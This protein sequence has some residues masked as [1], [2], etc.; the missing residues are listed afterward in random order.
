MKVLNQS[1]WHALPKPLLFGLYG[2]LG[3]LLGATVFGEAVWW[4]LQPPAPKVAVIP[5]LRLAASP[6]LELYQ[7]GA[8]R[9]SVKIAREGWAEPVTL[10]VVDPPPGVRIDAITIPATSGEAEVEVRAAADA[11]EGPKEITLKAEGAAPAGSPSAETTIRLTVRK[12]LPPPPALRL[13][14]S[15][16]VVLDQSSKNH[17]GVVIARDNFSGP[18][19]LDLGGLPAGVTATGVTVPADATRTEVE[20]Q[21]AADAAVGMAN[22]TVTAIGPRGPAEA[23]APPVADSR[24]RVTVNAAK[25]MPGVDVMFVLDVT[26]S[27]QFAIDGVRDGIIEFARELGERKLDARVGLVAFRDRLMSGRGFP[28][29]LRRAMP[30]GRGSSRSKSRTKRADPAP[31]PAPMFGG[32][33]GEEPFLIEVAGEVF[34]RNY[35][36][37]GREVGRKL[38]ANGG[39]DTPESS[40][41]GI[42]LAAAQKF[43][44]DATRVMILITDAPPKVP[45]KD[46]QTVEEAADILRKNQINQLHLVILEQF[47]ETYAPLQVAAPGTVFDLQVAAR[48]GGSFASLLP[49]VSREIAR[50]TVASQPA[51]PEAGSSSRPAP[52]V[53]PPVEAAKALPSIAPPA[54]LRGVQ[55]QET[56]AAESSG[57]LLVAIGA[58]TGMIA[59]MIALALCA[60]QHRYLKEGT[61]PSGAAVRGWLGGLVAGLVG[62]AA[63]QFLFLAAPGALANDAVSRVLGWTLLGSLAGLVLAF[64][65]PNLRFDRGLLGGAVGGAAG[66]LGY[67]GVTTAVRG[68]PGA[69]P[70]G[71]ILGAA[72]LGLALGLMLAIAERMARKAW[73][74][75]CYGGSE[76]RTVNL[77]LQPVSIGSDARSATIYARGVAP[78]AYRYWFKEGKVTRQDAT[79]DQVTEL[80]PGEPESVGAVTVTVRTA[81]TATASTSGPSVPTRPTPV[82]A[83]PVPG[84]VAAAPP[85]RPTSAAP[86]PVPPPAWRPPPAAPPPAPAPVPAS[87][88]VTQRASPA[89]ATVPVQPAPPVTVR[90]SSPTPAVASANSA[91]AGPPPAPKDPNKC[92]SCGKFVPG[93][94]GQ[95]Y[96]IQCD[97][98][99]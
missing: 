76:I 68:L 91:P 56:F 32:D 98:Y 13:S 51:A 77:G 33:D 74:E 94:P 4:L 2:A 16:E 38:R 39:G 95:R 11:S 99:L 12:T 49:D 64:F 1:F 5:P 8:N 66:A 82:A 83:P 35:A 24:L 65:V 7:G 73:L 61:L 92:P 63:G 45:D 25:R 90:P 72:L 87:P 47:R 54:V 6:A 60:G 81:S 48:G 70:S 78:V 19:V 55:S 97:I 42:A 22:V 69:D 88:P 37:F 85:S 28:A 9:F 3:G 20:L 52:P 58:W 40:L 89:K 26:G 10:K 14:V 53:A 23:P 86:P 34:T 71:R 30:K 41:D 75:I 15:P 29:A 59:A 21:A 36:E 67:I 17:F 96:C 57:R 43:R 46:T 18:V 31:G 93:V 44:P 62:G 50:I 80:R 84:P 79:T 27:M